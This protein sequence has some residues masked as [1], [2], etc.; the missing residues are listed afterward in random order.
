MFAHA[1][2]DAKYG[3]PDDCHF[4][5]GGEEANLVTSVSTHQPSPHLILHKPQMDIDIP[6]S[7]TPSSSPGKGHLSLD[8]E[9]PW[10]KYVQWLDLSAE[11]GI[12]EEGWVN[13]AK[14]RGYTTLR[15]PGVKKTKSSTYPETPKKVDINDLF[16]DLF[17][18]PI[19]F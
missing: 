11:L 5:T 4:T 3:E 14:S 1:N 17:P 19:A 7:Y 16:A 2:L 6:H 15:K 9:V 18:P 10:D 12:I 13:A 8:I